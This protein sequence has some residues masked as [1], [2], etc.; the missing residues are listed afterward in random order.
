MTTPYAPDDVG[1]TVYHVLGA[2][3]ASE[4]R[5]RQ[6]RPVQLNRGQV[7]QALFTGAAT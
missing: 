1:A 3:P 6:G 4:V 5:D 7:M 2:N